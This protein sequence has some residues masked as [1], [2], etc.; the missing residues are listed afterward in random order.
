MKLLRFLLFPLSL[1]YDLVTS[2]R[3]SLFDKGIFKET[4]FEIPV[5]AVGNL[6]VGGTGKTPQIEYLIRLLKI[7]YSLAV[8]SRGYKRKTKGFLLL[9]A[10]HTATDVGD[11][12]LQFFQKFSNI[13]VAVDADRVH[14]VQ[15]L[16]QLEPSPEVVLLD[17][18]YQHRKIKA[19]F[20]ILL[21]K[22][23]DLYVNDFILPTGNLRESSRGAQR[24][25]MIV[26]TKCP[27]NLSKEAQQQIAKKL[28]ITSAQLLFFST[29]AYA[30]E[31]KGRETIQTKTLRAY[32]IVVVTGIANPTPLLQFLDTLEVRYHHLKFPDHY[33]F[34][35]Q[36]AHKIQ[37]T[38]DEITHANKMILTTEKDY[39]RLHGMVEELYYLPIR[40]QFL[41]DEGAVFN[42]QLL[43]WI[44]HIKK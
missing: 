15:Q 10:S 43:N 28:Q 6:N 21:T 2:V 19:G 16:L 5:I 13:S 3:N 42:Q 31:I 9:N 44:D 40:T 33:Q 4:S 29:I 41:N 25:N 32:E 12:P 14:G 30:D 17:D 23:N 24:A 1:L 18:A 37:E 38:L 27:D 35:E 20:Y 34:T 39:T 7:Q 11:E 22:Y 26:V 8:L 36:D